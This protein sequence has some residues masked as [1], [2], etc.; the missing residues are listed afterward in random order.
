[1]IKSEP[2]KKTIDKIILLYNHKN[3][4]EAINFSI[5]ILKKYSLG[6]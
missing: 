5:K 4:L 2:D 1:M 3:Y 6:L